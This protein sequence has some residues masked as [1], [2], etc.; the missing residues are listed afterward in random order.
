[1]V[2]SA[3]GRGQG[4]FGHGPFILTCPTE[5]LKVRKPL[6]TTSKYGLRLVGRWT[7]GPLLAEQAIQANYRSLPACHSDV[8]HSR[9]APLSVKSLTS[10]S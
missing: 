9:A 2:T 8:N 7:R 4:G 1:M 3:V 10:A 6:W 5:C